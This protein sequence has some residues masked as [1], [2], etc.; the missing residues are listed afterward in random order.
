MYVYSKVFYPFDVMVHGIVSLFPFLITFI[1]L[2]RNAADFC[3][4]ILCP[5]TLPN[6]LMS[7]SSFFSA[8]FRVSYVKYNVI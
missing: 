7:S 2:Y 8:L 3:I 1:F 5:T 6:L 4:S